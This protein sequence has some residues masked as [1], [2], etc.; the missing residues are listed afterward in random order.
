[1]KILVIG[2]GG[3]EHALA[4]KISQSQLATS[5]FVAPGNA[6]TALEPMIM[7]IDIQP[8]NIPALLDCA[9]TKQIDLTIVGPE[10]PLVNGV[11]D[12]FCSAGLKI[13][14][15]TQSAAL[16]EGSKAF[17]KDF[18]VRHDILTAEYQHFT[19]VE[20]A[21]SYVRKR[22]MPIVIKVDG[23]ADGKGVIVARTL[24]EAK[25]AIH[26]MLVENV[27]G[28]SGR[29]IIIEEFLEGEEVSFIVMVDGKNVL[30]IASCQDYKCVGNGDIGPNTGGMGAFSPVKLVTEKMHQRIMDEVILPTIRAMVFEGCSYTGFLYAGLMINKNSQIYV[31]E[32][33]CRLGDPESQP[34]LLRLQ[35]D[36]L[37]LCLAAI[38]GKLDQKKVFLDPRPALGVVLASHGYPG[39]Y[40]KGNRIYGLPLSS[41]GVDWKVFHS[42][43]AMQDGVIVTNGG[44]VVCVTALGEDLTEAKNYAYQLASQ[45]DWRGKFFR[46]DIG[47]R[48]ISC[49]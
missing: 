23:L 11:V 44:R 26:N 46:T 41:S 21:L 20:L 22:R 15:P 42:G 30:P 47:E 40:I 29:R 9:M 16:L 28:A 39:N 17:T 13:F 8:N 19:D 14:G 6:G 48:A 45:I 34:M 35:S 37:D 25:S 7:N 38:D 43:T 1:M 49:A 36:L 27:F 32:F 3:R 10:F 5:V 33:N 12:I 18:L 24:Q 2:N 31:L 4:W